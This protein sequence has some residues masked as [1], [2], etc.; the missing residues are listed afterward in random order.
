MRLMVLADGRVGAEILAH[1]AE[2]FPDDLAVIVV[3]DRSLLPASCDPT[4]AMVIEYASESQVADMARGL[5][6][7]L[8]ITAWWPFILKD[9]LLALARNGFINTHP[10]MLPFNRGKHYNFWAIVERCRFGVSLH[11]I[12]TGIDSGDIV[13]Q[14]E[15]AVDWTD[16]GGTL[17]DKAQAAMVE[18]FVEAYPVIRTGRHAR[19]PQDLTQGSFHRSVEIEPASRI[20]LDRTYRARDL[21]DLLRA[22]TFDGKPGCWFEE[23]GLR[24]EARIEVRRAD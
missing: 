8:G 17:Y 16:T 19:I 12:G 18:L 1:L 20:E 3:R 2:L 22:R 23:D 21:L 14:R 4:R 15:I 9:Q 6:I 7:D 24:Y 5:D 11:F 10:S 13:A